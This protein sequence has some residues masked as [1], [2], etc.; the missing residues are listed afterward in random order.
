MHKLVKKLNELKA[1]ITRRIEVID[2]ETAR[3]A[4]ERLELSSAIK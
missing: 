1:E 3:L 4:D 2:G